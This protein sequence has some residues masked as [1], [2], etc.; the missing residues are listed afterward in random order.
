MHPFRLASWEFRDQFLDR[1][2]SGDEWGE[3]KL[4]ADAWSFKVEGSHILV[5]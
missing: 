2:E 4:V 3:V 5:M 1:D